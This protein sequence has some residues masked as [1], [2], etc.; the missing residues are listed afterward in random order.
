MSRIARTLIISA[1]FIAY[2]YDTAT[3]QN[4]TNSNPLL[5]TTGPNVLPK[6]GIQWNNNL[7]YYYLGMS[8]GEDY[9]KVN[10]N[11]FGANTGLR[12]GIGSQSELNLDIKGAY[13]TFD[14]TYFHNTTGFIPSVGVKLLLFEGKGWLP[15]IAF[16]TNVAMPMRQN[17]YNSNWSYL[18]QPEIGL[19]F[20]NT[21]GANS[22]FD[23]SLGYS[24]N[25]LGSA[26]SDPNGLLQ[27]SLY[28]RRLVNDRQTFGVGID[29]VNS[30]HRMAGFLEGRW[31]TTDKLQLIG[32]FGCAFG[33][34]ND[35][36]AGAVMGLFGIR[37]ILK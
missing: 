2:G 26:L 10:L 17:A 3:A 15:Q 19:Q 4:D 32:K 31:Q 37:W 33:I 21:V 28:Y 16:F 7:E 25:S 24:W 13:N 9:P 6:G 1:L 20:R 35:G 23:Y 14:T 5:S 34:G 18:V 29:N 12:F 8:I 30:A 27:Y 11:S 22:V 36:F